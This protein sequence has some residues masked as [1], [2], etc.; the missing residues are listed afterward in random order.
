M[1]VNLTRNIGLPGEMS[2]GEVEDVV[3]E[4]L[5]MGRQERDP[6]RRGNVPPPP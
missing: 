6:V 5:D 2:E 3:E 1:G 4:A